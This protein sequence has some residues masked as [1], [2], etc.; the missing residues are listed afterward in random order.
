M[1][2]DTGPHPIAFLSKERVRAAAPRLRAAGVDYP[3]A[4][5]DRAL[6]EAHAQYE[7][8]VRAV[9]EREEQ[10]R[11]REHIREEEGET[12]EAIERAEREQRKEFFRS[13]SAPG[14]AA[15]HVG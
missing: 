7:R 13:R 11:L 10:A 15:V 2:A 9:V 4:E 14:F 12:R 3:R 6:A 8:A 1:F 5:E